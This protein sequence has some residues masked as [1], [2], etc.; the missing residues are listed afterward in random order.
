MYRASDRRRLRNLSPAA[1][2]PIA[3][4][5]LRAQDRVMRVSRVT[6]VLAIAESRP[7]HYIVLTRRP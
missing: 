1:V 6:C 3:P 5:P 2:C 4:P 7:D